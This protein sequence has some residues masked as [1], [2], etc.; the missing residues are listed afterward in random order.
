[1]MTARRPTI[2]ALGVASRDEVRVLDRFPDEGGWAQVL[3]SY[4]TVGGTTA[5]LAC[6]AQRLGANVSLFAKFGEDANGQL[7]AE[8]LR[9]AGLD[10]ANVETVAAPMDLSIVLVSRATG[11][12][13]ILWEIGPFHQRGDRIDIEALFGADLTVIDSPDIPLRRFLTDLPAHTNPR[14]RLLGT[15]SYLAAVPDQD[16]LEIAMRHDV[17]VGSEREYQIL[18][19]CDSGAAG[20]KFVR[21]QMAGSNLRSAFMTCGAAGAIAVDKSQALHIAAASSA[22]IDTTGAGDAFAG[23]VAYAQAMRQD[24]RQSLLLATAVAGVVVSGLGAQEFQ[25]SLEVAMRLMETGPT[26][27]DWS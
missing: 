18:T 4:F 11:E 7:V 17:L 22:V 1:M 19:G 14:S 6:A 23:A 2:A 13:T 15:L 27:V 26:P 10:L 20:L 16:K 9:H 25:P 8:Q 21:D 3:E 24:L 12:R 5:N